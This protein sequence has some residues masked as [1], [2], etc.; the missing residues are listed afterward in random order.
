M[1]AALILVLLFTL[2]PVAAMAAGGVIAAYRPPQARL[3]S[4]IQHFAAGVVFAALAVEVLPDV[5]HRDEP[6]AA[7][8]GFAP[9]SSSVSNHSALSTSAVSTSAL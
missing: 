1:S 5:V 3:S 8:A 2:A 4:S 9:V 7:A 6:F